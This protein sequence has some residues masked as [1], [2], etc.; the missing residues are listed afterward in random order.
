MTC[1]IDPFK[2]QRVA[3]AIKDRLLAMVIVA[4]TTLIRMDSGISSKVV[5][6]DF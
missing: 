3:M 6:N 4:T 5:A 1:F 2:N